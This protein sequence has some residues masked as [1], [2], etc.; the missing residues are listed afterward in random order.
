MKLQAKM[1]L[2][3]L[4]VSLLSVG[5]VGVVAYGL[6]MKD[7]RQ[8]VK[9]QAFANYQQDITD[10]LR[11]YG[12][13]QAGQRQEPFNRFVRRRRRPPEPPSERPLRQ[14]QPPFHF[15]TLD[16]AGRVLNPNNDY[17]V[18]D[19]VPVA[20]LE[21]ARPIEIDGEVKL[22]VVQIGE[23]ALNENDRRYLRVMREALLLGM[24]VA[25]AFV[26]LLGLFLGRRLSNNIRLLTGAVHQMKLDGEL[27]EEVRIRSR[28]EIAELANVFNTMNANLVRTH[29]EL[30]ES[31]DTIGMQAAK[32]RELS[33]RDPLTG[34]FNRRHFDQQAEMNYC[35]AVRYGRPLTVMIGDL[36]HFKRIND[37]YSHAVGDEVL[38][39]V[40]MILRQEVRKSDLIARYG[41]EEFVL[42]FPET[43]LDDALGICDK[44][45]RTIEAHPWYEVHSNLRVTMSMG[46]CDDLSLDSMEKMIARAD[47]CLYKAKGS[48]RNRVV[49]CK[50]LPA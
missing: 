45:R 34:L 5:L 44:L 23:P 20:V 36:D 13:L 15:L 48:G 50:E 8:G 1:T 28:D 29:A 27:P 38:R 14:G 49:S 33:V 21:Q 40:A 39:R 46:L 6:L 37:Y 24:A 16:S 2:T 4:L 32:L 30:Q 18:G 17:P 47:A 42:L 25:G 11:Q 31:H 22:L 43:E 41:G 35:Q 3:L 9:D 19:R 26:L 10:Y 12:S 7:F